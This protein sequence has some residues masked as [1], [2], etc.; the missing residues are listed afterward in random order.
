[1]LAIVMGVASPQFTRLIEPSVQS[2]ISDTNARM[3][4]PA[5]A[6]ARAAAALAAEPAAGDGR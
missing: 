2:L 5:T 1:V 6:P 3:R 4:R